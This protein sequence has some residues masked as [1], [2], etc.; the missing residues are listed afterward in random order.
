MANRSEHEIERG[1]SGSSG[2]G[3][4]DRPGASLGI[5]DPDDATRQCNVDPT[6]ATSMESHAKRRVRPGTQ[7]LAANATRVVNLEQSWQEQYTLVPGCGREEQLSRGCAQPVATR[8]K[9]WPISGGSAKQS[10]TPTSGRRPLSMRTW[11]ECTRRTET[12]CWF[13]KMASY[14]SGQAKEMRSRV[15]DRRNTDEG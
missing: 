12:C 9:I 14:W 2:E 8:T 1:C 13:K 7:G 10:S 3:T 15:E 11:K 5:P 4:Q 6:V